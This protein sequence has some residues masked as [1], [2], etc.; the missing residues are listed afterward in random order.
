MKKL[1][2]TILL[3]LFLPG[4]H[5]LL[6]QTIT[7]IA[8]NGYINYSGDGFAATAAQLW[9]P[10]GVATDGTGNL[11][12]ADRYNNCVRKVNISGVFST[13][14]GNGSI[15]YS[16]DGGPATAAQLHWP[17]SVTSDLSGNIYI[18]D[19][20]NNVIRKVNPAGVI[21]TCAGS[22]LYGDFGDTGPATAAKIS[23]PTSIAVDGIGNMYICDAVNSVIRKVN[24]SGVIT[25]FAGKHTGG[26]SGDGGPASAAFL[27]NSSGVAVD[28][29]GNV[30]I[31]DGYNNRIRKVNTSGIISTIAGKGTPG[32]SG[33]GSSATDAGLNNPVS[34]KADAGGNIYFTDNGNNCI[35]KVNASGI[36]STITGDGTPNFS[37]D[38]GVATA[39][40]L[41]NPEELT[42]DGPGNI[43]VADA[44]NNRVR[45][46]NTSGKI[47]TVAGGLSSGRPALANAINP[48]GMIVDG[49]GNLL[50]ADADNNRICRI[51][52]SGILTVLAGSGIEGSNG[53]GV[54]ATSAEIAY[55]LGIAIDRSGNMYIAETDS[56]RV[57]K[58]STSGVISTIAGNGKGAFSGD[59][60][61]ATNAQLWEPSGIAVDGSGNIYIADQSNKRVRKINTSG[62]IS[63]FAG[64]GLGS[65][66]GDG[67]PATD[68]TLVR[69]KGVAT[70]SSGNVYIADQYNNRI[71]KI[72]TSGIISTVAGTSTSGFSGD[73]GPATNAQLAFPTG[74]AIDGSGN[75]YITGDNRYRK[76]NAL[77]IIT[78][79]AGK[80]TYGFTGDGG[81]ATA[82]ELNLPGSL[83][84]DG[85]GNVYISDYNNFR[86]RKVQSSSLPPL[87]GTRTLCIG[88][89][90]TLSDMV[91]GGT[92]TSLTTTVA[93]VGPTSGIV[94]G[95]SAGT[96]TIVYDLNDNTVAITVTVNPL[97]ITPAGITG[98]TAVCAGATTLLSDV[99]AGGAWSSVN[100][101]IAR[102]GPA[103]IVTGVTAG[104]TTISY[105]YTNSCGSAAAMI[106]VTVNPLPPSPAGITETTK[107]CEG[108]GTTALSDTTTGGAWSSNNTAIAIISPA[109]IVTGIAAGTTIISYTNIN[110]CGSASVIITL[111]VNPLPIT[112]AGITGITKV[113]AGGATTALSDITAGGT[114]SS[115][116][117]A[118]ATISS[119]GVVTGITTGTTTISYTYTN[120]CGSAFAITTVTVNPLP[121]A[122]A[123]GTGICVSA[124]MSLSDP[125]AGGAWSSG[126]TTILTVDAGTGVVTGV[127]PGSATI[128]YTLPAGCVITAEVVVNPLPVAGV[129]SGVS[130]VCIDST[131]IL[132]N[133]ITGGIWASNN[134]NATV[135]GSGAVTG[136]SPGTDT[137][138]YSVTNVCG[139]DIASWHLNVIQCDFTNI[140][141]LSKSSAKLIVY[142]N[143]N[144]GVFTVN[145]LSDYEEQVSIVITD[146]AGEKV[147]EI[148]TTTN[149][150]VNIKPGIAPGIYLLSG[151]TAHGKYVAKII[152]NP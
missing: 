140:P 120:S 37:G 84:I 85:S 144:D 137:I 82:G 88:A 143:P 5:C 56:N 132:S 124:A 26:F 78:T 19:W 148:T 65:Y 105:T 90:I 83:A 4:T 16:G 50:F 150:P 10:L 121:S 122:I 104:T 108:G 79:M 39:A 92:W 86:I 147:K 129:I 23:T 93:T 101:A 87:T 38:G 80:G 103:G 13:F 58:V 99:T 135:T 70:D 21:S 141:G 131:I 139:T 55:P 81:P 34:V 146:I 20:S 51:N 31:A 44:H 151:T 145:L 119:S 110:S 68:A 73:G 3:L 95:V 61:P 52:T 45:K 138:V 109:G 1:L 49:S 33:D 27:N 117:T 118:I 136:V 24:T 113:C 46:V 29:I 7:T 96:A 75:I 102:T 123:G 35:R 47:S 2:I 91:A 25:T 114:W 11:Y 53:D 43:Y 149:N 63:T 130:D 74:L 69:P 100:T 115:N 57:R 15:G 14:A 125:S 97:P 112:P 64:I 62:I 71:R 116:T 77:G 9:S 28:A 36:I 41:N 59:G 152:V 106:T 98:I 18:A 48:W 126:N 94:M 12:I 72:N 6:G 111:T 42:I 134:A 40:E 66:L 67:G 142:P 32:Y 107:V 30:F 89:K 22:G 17:V 8:G 54:P 127:S 133:A 76:I 128:T 60:G